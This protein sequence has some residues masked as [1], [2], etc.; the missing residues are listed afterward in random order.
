MFFAATYPERTAGLVLI[1]AYARYARSEDTP[2]GLPEGQ[3]PA[4]VTAI[5]DIWGTGALSR[6]S[7]RPSSARSRRAGTGVASNV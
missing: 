7:P 3:I 1:N 6:P 2:W 4:Y 5:E